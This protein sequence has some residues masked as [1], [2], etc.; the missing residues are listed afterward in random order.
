MSNKRSLVYSEIL[1]KSQVHPQHDRALQRG[2]AAHGDRQ[3]EAG[4][5]QRGR[6]QEFRLG[7][8]TQEEGPQKSQATR[9][10]A[11]PQIRPVRGSHDLH[12]CRRYYNTDGTIQCL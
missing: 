8:P 9:I 6:E 11:T 1:T 12:D 5:V 4:E 2:A 7:D 3:V 10:P